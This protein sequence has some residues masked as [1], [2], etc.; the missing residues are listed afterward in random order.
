MIK[1]E[2]TFF[3]NVLYNAGSM[4]CGFILHKYPIISLA[5]FFNWGNDFLL[6]VMSVLFTIYLLTLIVEEKRDS[7]IE[8]CQTCWYHYFSWLPFCCNLLTEKNALSLEGYS[9]NILKSRP[10]IHFIV[11][12]SYCLIFL[13]KY[14]FC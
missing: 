1:Q 11:V 9:L 10:Y 5:N 2:L 8:P 12:F 14:Y 4:R 7:S 13:R 6:Q 3:Q